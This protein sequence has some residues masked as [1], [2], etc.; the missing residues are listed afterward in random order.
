MWT[1][2][3]KVSGWGRKNETDLDASA[4]LQV[5]RIRIVK[6]DD[7]RRFYRSRRITES[8]LCAGG[9]IRDACKGDSGGPLTCTN[10]QNNQTYLC[11]IVSWGDVKC[12]ARGLPGVYTDVAKYFQWIQIYTSILES[13]NQRKQH[14][15]FHTKLNQICAWKFVWFMKELHV[16]LMINFRFKYSWTRPAAFYP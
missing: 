11:G 10:S 12:R 9:R 1:V 13:S 6:W 2:L 16:I 3:A 5:A 8:M 14:L 7:C 15:L 4:V